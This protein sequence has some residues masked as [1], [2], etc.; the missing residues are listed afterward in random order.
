MSRRGDFRRATVEKR[1]FER[2]KPDLDC[3]E[4]AASSH[5]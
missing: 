4:K 2:L 1:L 3:A 5:G